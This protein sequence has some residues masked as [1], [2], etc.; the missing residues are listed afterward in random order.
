V[1]TQLFPHSFRL[2]VHSHIFVWASHVCPVPHVTLQLPQWAL[3]L[4]GTQAVPGPPH[5][6]VPAGHL[7]W[8]ASHDIPVG[9]ASQPPQCTLVLSETQSLPPPPHWAVPAGQS[10]MPPSHIV[11]FMHGLRHMPQCCSS[12]FKS[13]HVLPHGVVPGGQSFTHAPF[14][15]ISPVMHVTPGHPPQCFSLVRVSTQPS[16]AQRV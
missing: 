2:P 4:S 1:S 7:H 9:H 8:P 5:W 13:A 6:A 11:P 3:V 16:A 14:M 10:H 15:Q 12:V